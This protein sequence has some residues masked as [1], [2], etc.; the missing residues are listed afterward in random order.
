MEQGINWSDADRKQFYKADQ[1]SRIMPYQWLAALKQKDGSPFL[2]SSLARYG[3]LKD[4]DDANNL[5][6]GFTASGPAGAQSVGMTCSACHTRQI[7]V[8]EVKYRIDGGPA[9]VDFQAFLADLDAAVADVLA[10][11]EN[12]RA[13]AD[14]VLR[15]SADPSDAAILKLQ[16]RD[17]HMR[18]HMLIEASLPLAGQKAWGVGR[19]DAISMI[20]N[21][22]TGLDIGQPPNFI[23]AENI[24]RAD[25]PARYPFL[26]NAPVQDKTQWAGFASNGRDLLALSRNVGQVMGVFAVF[27]PKNEGSYVNFLNRNS[28]NFDGLSRIE[29]LVKKIGPPK[30][31]WS[32]DL[33]LAAQG[34]TI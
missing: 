2:S 26:W 4:P 3:Y 7:A 11:D 6:I 17:W 27:H 29:R 5:P 8:G 31:P 15:T 32:I 22:V 9:L 1:G 34:K 23:I 33:A 13:F 30:W 16:V 20:F 28:V 19:L 18:Y 25:A 10:N 21:R 14:A 24:K 12:F